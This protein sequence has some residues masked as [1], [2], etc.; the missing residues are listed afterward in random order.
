MNV[1]RLKA[2]AV[3]ELKDVLRDYHTLLLMIAVPVVLYPFIFGS[4]MQFSKQVNKTNDEQKV[5]VAIVG[6]CAGLAETFRAKKN[7]ELV[8]VAASGIKDA[9]AKETIDAAII[10]PDSF[11]EKLTDVR[12]KPSQLRLQYDGR[13]RNSFV[14]LIRVR[15]ILEEYRAKESRRRLSELGL[16]TQWWNTAEVKYKEAASQVSEST[17]R[18]A[19]GLPFM[20][21]VLILS[22]AYYASIDIVTGERERGTL[23]VLLTA[24][25]KRTEIMACKFSIVCVIALASVL[26]NLLST[27][28]ASS[29]G[30]FDLTDSKVSAIDFSPVTIGLALMVTLPLIAFLSA[31]SMYVTAY[32]S[33]FQQG[34]YYFPLLLIVVLALAAVSA[35]PNVT[36]DSAVAF[37]PVANA[38]VCLREICSGVYNWPWIAVVMV[39]SLVASLKLVQITAGLLEREDILFGIIR[40]PQALRREGSFKAIMILLFVNVLL[41]FYVGLPAQTHDILFGAIAVQIFVIALPALVFVRLLRLPYK[42]TLSLRRPSWQMM[43]CAACLLPVELFFVSILAKL[44][45]LILPNTENYMEVLARM[46]I[47]EGRPVWFIIFAI[48]VMPGIC[49]ELLFRGTILGTLSHNK[50]LST[51]KLIVIVGLLFG[52]LHLSIVRLMPTVILGMVLTWLTIRARSIFPSMLLHFMNNAVSV[53]SVVY[54]IEF[55]TVN[56]FL[57][58]CVGL[59]LFI[60]FYLWDERRRSVTT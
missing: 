11:A 40:S 46:L 35:L 41:N 17:R 7:V 18:I 31:S 20:L 33:S 2:L 5:K 39:S 14:S 47:P 29:I 52:F 13:M 34:G 24:P 4:M 30:F 54:S 60:V 3:K 56:G 22:S 59:V 26:L 44:Q 36:L 42:E 27:Y 12:S 6:D 58:G 51:L 57:A 45:A 25:V 28:I 9:I 50:K 19:Q 43:A 23:Q 16:A 37:L 10:V 15:E 32:A 48:A 38:A 21:V 55:L 53:L 49:E 8:H 1:R